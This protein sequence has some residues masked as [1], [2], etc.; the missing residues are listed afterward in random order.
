MFA[1]RRASQALYLVILLTHDGATSAKLVVTPSAG[2][3]RKTP[4]AR[5]NIGSLRQWCS[6][7]ATL[8]V[9]VRFVF[10][11][12]PDWAAQLH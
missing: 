4:S 7:Q 1:M 8:G 2:K 9:F 11:T 12:T 10:Q 5:N 6:R 3:R